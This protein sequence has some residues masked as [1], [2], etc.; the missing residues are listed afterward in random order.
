MV[1]SLQGTYSHMAPEVIQSTEFSEVSARLALH[2]PRAGEPQLLL[3]HVLPVLGHDSP[4]GY[5]IIPWV[6]ILQLR[7][8]LSCLSNLIAIPEAPGLF[9]ILG[10]ECLAGTG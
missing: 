10:S 7:C 2:R 5:R 3:C 4:E 9:C 6:I 1:E 8:I